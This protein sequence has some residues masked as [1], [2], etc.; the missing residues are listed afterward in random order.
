MV[1]RILSILLAIFG[2]GA[3]HGW[4]QEASAA[5][6]VRKGHDLAVLICA[7]CHLAAPD[8][9]AMPFLKPPAPSFESI[10]QR[11]TL[12]VDFIRTF[13]ATTHRDIRNPKGMPNPELADFQIEQVGAYIM[14]LRRRP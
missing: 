11:K 13:M 9:A 1:A 14:S 6:D 10:A 7:Y 3:T 2:L 12:S 4:A 5:D 8:Q